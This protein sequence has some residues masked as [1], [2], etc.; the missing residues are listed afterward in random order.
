L[1]ENCFL[2]LGPCKFVK[3]KPKGSASHQILEPGIAAATACLRSVGKM[4]LYRNV[5][6]LEQTLGHESKLTAGEDKA[7]ITLEV[8][9]HACYNLRKSMKPG[10]DKC[11]TKL[12][13]ASVQPFFT[14]PLN[15]DMVIQKLNQSK[16]KLKRTPTMRDKHTQ[17]DDKN[18]SKNETQVVQA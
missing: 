14:L 6:R 7:A 13:C 4:R 2:N 17:G 12:D 11:D 9:K 3:S 18:A 10:S 5:K 8:G 16:R 1:S 15:F